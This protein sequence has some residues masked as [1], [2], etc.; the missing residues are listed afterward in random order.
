LSGLAAPAFSAFLYPPVLE[1]ADR[2]GLQPRAR[3]ERSGSI[4]D[5]GTFTPPENRCDN[6][7]RC[8]KSQKRSAERVSRG[9]KRSGWPLK[10]IHK[11]QSPNSSRKNPAL[12]FTPLK[13]EALFI[14]A[15][16]QQIHTPEILRFR[17]PWF[18]S[19][20]LP[21]LSA[22]II[23]RHPSS[24]VNNYGCNLAADTFRGQHSS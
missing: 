21:S 13:T 9:R 15:P 8:L 19:A 14:S 2:R 3:S 5:W 24:S 7:T 17:R 11:K 18:P 6:S 22:V 16:F 1:L 12:K 10:A 20:C 4:P 23:R